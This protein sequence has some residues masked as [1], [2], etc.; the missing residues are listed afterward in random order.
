MWGIVL[1]NVFIEAIWVGA[2]V[3]LIL[4]KHNNW[5]IA[6]L[7]GALLCGYNYK[8]RKVD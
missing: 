3:I 2:T 8:K 1:A 6:T 7:C 4:T 5:A